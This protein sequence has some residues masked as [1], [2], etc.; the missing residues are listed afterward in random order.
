[1]DDQVLCQDQKTSKRPRRQVSDDK[2]LE[3]SYQKPT[4][5]DLRE[6]WQ[7]AQNSGKCTSNFQEWTQSEKP[8]KFHFIIY[9]HHV[10]T[11][12]GGGTG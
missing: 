3:N 1:M 6:L 10:P 7:D 11:F 8:A 4:R 5:R 9:Q 12:F 2:G